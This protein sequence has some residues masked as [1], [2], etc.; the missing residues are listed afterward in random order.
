MRNAALL[1][2]L[3]AILIILVIHDS[4]QLAGRTLVASSWHLEEAESDSA[5]EV[6]IV[7]AIDDSI[8]S[9][10][11]DFCSLVHITLTHTPS[12]WWTT[13][14]LDIVAASQQE[15]DPNFIYKNW[16]ISLLASLTP[17]MLL[18]GIRNHPSAHSVE[19]ILDIVNKRIIDPSSSPPL[20]IAVL[21][22]SVTRGQGCDVPRMSGVPP[23][24]PTPCAWPARLERLINTLAG[25]Q[26]VQVHNLAVSA[27]DLAFG[28]NLVEY[29]LYPE[30][31]LPHGPDVIIASHSTNEQTRF[32]QYDS[33]KFADRMYRRV[34]NFISAVHKA[35][36]CRPPL[37]IFVD[38]YLGNPRQDLIIGEMA[39]NK[40]VTELAEWYG[41]MWHVSYA[42]V[43]RRA[44]YANT[45]E[46][47]FTER[48]P[49]GTLW[50]GSGP[51]HFG[52]GGHMAIAWTVMYAMVEAISD[53]CDNQA[54]AKKMKQEG[55][56]GVF[57]ESVL[58]L[59][60]TVPPPKLSPKLLLSTITSEWQDAA[61][62]I[63]E[64]DTACNGEILDETPCTFAF[65][66]GPYATVQTPEQLNH[67]LQP[68]LVKNSGWKPL[69]EY[70]AN[71]NVEKPG[72]V[73]D[74][75]NASMT[76][77]MTNITKEV[78]A[79]KLQTIK[80]YGENWTDSPLHFDCGE[81]RQYVP[82]T[83]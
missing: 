76:L 42:D 54:F 19:R 15:E 8:N 12:N 13:H 16:T 1:L 5:V 25:F 39:V 29:W 82:H 49:P 32:Y 38:D 17:E 21:G 27:T 77:R 81:S 78:H 2:I 35:R 58:T 63:R 24:S 3:V 71:R 62:R 65:L 23:F 57:P 40:V 20:K 6:K 83:V 41:N 59:M 68:F 48:W 64:N 9:N 14:F 10:T 56:E 55:Y 18:K 72:L 47:I 67:Y 51:I 52:M 44:I 34:N 61:A 69:M 43:L 75:A 31:L 60:N 74:S 28:T 50:N 26:V 36:P 45:Q 33:I 22:G 7:S 80:S 66:A 73:A 4:G 46:T 37:V 11:D 53:Y 30:T 70:G 79:V